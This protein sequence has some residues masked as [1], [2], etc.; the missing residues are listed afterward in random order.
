MI[1]M[2]KRNNF[3]CFGLL[4]AAL[5]I[6]HYVIVLW[7][8]V[9]MFQSQKALFSW[10]A[11]GIIGLLGLLSVYLLNFTGLKKLWDPGV[12]IRHK[13]FYPLAIGLLLGSIQS[14]YDMLTGASAE[15]AASMG[16]GGIHIAFPFSIPVYTGGAIIVCTIY[17]LIPI[18]LIV[19]LVSNRILKGKA[20][21]TVF[22]TVGILI[23]LFEPLTNPG[24]SVIQ[25]VGAVAIPMSVFVLVFNLVSITFIRKYGFITAYFL[26]IGEYAIWHILYPVL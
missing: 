18:S 11:I 24:I 16:L 22:W 2:Q 21:A 10:P 9:E 4:M 7:P 8:G 6:V 3:I 14:V 12:G 17:Y 13:V 19:Y 20:E 1:K 25:D 23:A 15:I 26:R 5:I